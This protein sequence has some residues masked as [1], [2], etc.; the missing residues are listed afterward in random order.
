MAHDY[1]TSNQDLGMNQSTV[2]E[3]HP[4]YKVAEASPRG[5][6]TTSGRLGVTNLTDTINLII[7]NYS[8]RPVDWLVSLNGV[9]VAQIHKDDSVTLP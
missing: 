4:V 7:A 6:V 2:L 1:I 5:L 8:N 9:I 3:F